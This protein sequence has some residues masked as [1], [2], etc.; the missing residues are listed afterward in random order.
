MLLL[1]E[2]FGPEISF[3]QILATEEYRDGQYERYK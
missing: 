3:L 2:E 1:K